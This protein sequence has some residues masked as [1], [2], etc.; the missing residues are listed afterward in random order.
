MSTFL[1]LVTNHFD[2]LWRRCWDKRIEADGKTYVSYADLEE[3]YMLDHLELARRCPDYK[4]EAESAIV[5]EKFLERHPELHDELRALAKTDRFA[6]PGSGYVIVDANMIRGES[7]VRNFVVGL[8][9]VEKTIGRTAKRG[10]RTDGFGNS[11]QLPQ[12]FRGCGIAWVN[13]LSYAPVTRTYWRGLD[14]TAVCRTLLPGAGHSRGGKGP[15]WMKYFPCPA[16]KGT[17]CDECNGR[18]IDARTTHMTPPGNIKEEAAEEF[19]AAIIG[20]G[21][22]ETLPCPELIDWYEAEKKKRDI[23]FA[24]SDELLPYVQSLVD[25]VDDPPEDE[26]H[27]GVELNPTDTGCLVTRIKTKQYVRQ[28]EHAVQQTEAFWTMACLNGGTWPRAELDQI[29]RKLLFTM[30]HDCIT[31]THTD[32]AYEELDEIYLELEDSIWRL[33]ADALDHLVTPDPRTVSVVNPHG[34]KTTQVAV[35]TIESETLALGLVDEDGKPVTVLGTY[36]TGNPGVVDVEFVASEVE[37]MGARRYGVVSAD[38]DPNTVTPLPEPVIENERFRVEADDN[39]IVAVYD[40]KLGANILEQAEYR[41]GE[42]ILEH[43]EGSPWETLGSD[44]SRLPLADSTRLVAA[45]GKPGLQRLVFSVRPPH[46]SGFAVGSMSATVTVSLV[47][48]I[49]RVDFRTEVAWHAWNHRLRVA[50]PIPFNGRHLYEIPYGVLERRPYEPWFAWHAGNGDWATINWAGVDGADRSVAVMNKGLPSYRIDDGL[51]KGSTLY[52]SMLRSPSVATHLCD[53]LHDA[54]LD[55]FG[56]M[57]DF[58]E[59]SFEYAVT[60]YDCALLESSVVMDAE[61][62]NAGLRATAGRVEL[63]EMPRVESDNV[64]VTCMKQAEDGNGV[65][66]RLHEFRG[67][68]GEVTIHLPAGCAS[69]EKTNLLER[70]GAPLELRDGAVTLTLRAWE[71]A[72]VR[73]RGV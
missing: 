60:A 9:W 26:I 21:G 40:K 42:L 62:Y 27:P 23:R 68:G 18:G 20:I 54:L 6:V 47:P 59:H 29:W 28:F 11:A 37:V 57:R 15:G 8:L 67:K 12:I 4:F 38:A 73:V 56:G 50:M 48:G 7:L 45:G 58:G 44:Q 70:E 36:E 41:P 17:G 32:P 72:T 19:G 3:Y 66:L 61:S 14:G 43:D 1:V 64:R 55:N 69:V 71:I 33:R 35:A 53:N 46:R 10:I 65:V 30:F 5:L 52:V 24:L 49:E 2:P 34:H 22:E 25:K 39:G 16:C 13:G 63:P 31:A 51:D